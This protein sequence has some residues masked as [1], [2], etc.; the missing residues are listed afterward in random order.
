[1]KN[2]HMNQN[3]GQKK[4]VFCGPEENEGT[5]ASAFQKVMQ[6]FGKVDFA[7]ADLNRVQENKGKGKE[8]KGKG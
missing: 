8:Q 1:M 6:A 7:L 2:K 3:C 5:K 4:I